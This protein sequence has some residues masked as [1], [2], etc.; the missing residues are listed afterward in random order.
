MGISGPVGTQAGVVCQPTTVG[1]RGSGVKE[2]G[3][4]VRGVKHVCVRS[5]RVDGCLPQDS[6]GQEVGLLTSSYRN[7]AR[8][9]GPQ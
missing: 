4:G 8:I 5:T 7:C 9:Q 3:T 6:V 1:L 2:G